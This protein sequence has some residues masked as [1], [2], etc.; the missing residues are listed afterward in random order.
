[1]M[2]ATTIAVAIRWTE[3]V[4]LLSFSRPNLGQMRV[5][6]SPIKNITIGSTASDVADTRAVA[7]ARTSAIL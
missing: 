7:G 5:R 3:T 1:M 4:F 2:P 6:T